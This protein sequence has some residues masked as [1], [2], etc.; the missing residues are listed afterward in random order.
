MRN[1]CP[2]C[3]NKVFF[4]FRL[5]ELA[6]I[7]NF[8]LSGSITL[9]LCIACSFGWNNTP[10]VE[11]DYTDYY[12]NYNKH[13]S[14]DEFG[15]QI[16]N[17]YF[18]TVLNRI[19]EL[20]TSFKSK[21]ILDY[22]S[23]DRSLAELALNI[24]FTNADCL[25][26]GSDVKKNGDYQ[27]LTCL[28]SLEHFYDP[29]KSVSEMNEL[30][31][32]GGILYI[33][34]PDAMRYEETYY[35]AYNAVDLEHINHFT[36]ASLSTL[37]NR[38]GFELIDIFQTDRKVSEEAFYPEIWVTAKKIASQKLLK[39]QTTSLNCNN[40]KFLDIWRSYILKSHNEF[41]KLIKWAEDIIAKH[42]S[43]NV[44]LYGLGS[45]ALRLANLLAKNNEIILGDS[46]LRVLD[47]KIGEISIKNLELIKKE[48]KNDHSHYLIAA[49]NGERIKSYLLEN[50]V[51]L[52]Q[53]SVFKWGK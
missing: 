19:K 13:Q 4:K 29:I 25:D 39:S 17:L 35:G 10:S 28:H 34:V 36:T 14:R 50:G 52:N 15:R 18:T 47:K 44:I 21:K 26:V 40:S 22:G 33:A 27:A 6:S 48:F 3:Q 2:V 30:L 11:K 24:G 12:L 41:N 49:V 7:S 1:I 38:C 20:T 37:L 23:G 42:E 31:C 8:P 46:D 53:I 16:D 5:P 9:N 51:N 32:D 45:P 43:K